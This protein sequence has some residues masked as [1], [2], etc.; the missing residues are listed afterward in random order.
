MRGVRSLYLILVLV[1]VL[2]ISSCD[3][4]NVIQESPYEFNCNIDSVYVSGLG[5]GATC[6]EDGVH[7]VCSE[8]DKVYYEIEYSGEGCDSVDALVIDIWDYWSLTD[9]ALSNLDYS[10]NSPDVS[11]IAISFE[12]IDGT[13]GTL[14]GAVAPVFYDGYM[15]PIECSEKIM[16]YQEGKVGVTAIKWD[17]NYPGDYDKAEKDYVYRTCDGCYINGEGPFSVDYGF[18]FAHSDTGCVGEEF[19][20]PSLPYSHP[21]PYICVRDN[22]GYEEGDPCDGVF[23]DED[24]TIHDYDRCCPSIEYCT[25]GGLC[26]PSTGNYDVPDDSEFSINIAEGLIWDHKN[27]GFCKGP[28]LISGS[29]G[30]GRW[31]DCDTDLGE[32]IN[33]HGQDDVP[34]YQCDNVLST[35]G[36]DRNACYV[37]NEIES[38]PSGEPLVGEYT[39]ISSIECCGDDSDE[40]LTTDGTI[41][42]CC[43]SADDYVNA[44]GLCS[45]YSEAGSFCDDGTC[46]SDEDCETC[47]EDCGIC[48]P[49]CDDGTCNSDEDCESCP[50]DC[51]VCTTENGDGDEG[52]GGGGSGSDCGD[53]YAEGSEECDMDDL[54]GQTCVGLGYDLGVLVCTEDCEFDE[55]GCLYEEVTP[56][57][58]EGNDN[59]FEEII[60]TYPKSKIWVLWVFIILAVA[61]AV[62][63]VVVARK[64]NER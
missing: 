44:V 58:T 11:G 57:D 39:Q 31:V 23:H 15:V 48:P 1:S 61:V 9:C 51:G 14:T 10:P 17:D 64:K 38:A 34:S 22:H 20:V 33:L 32:I 19:Y 56:V 54:D 27:I 55:S 26:Y 59:F 28:I 5:P 24:G 52:S 35:I 41:T 53:G 46:N 6:Q 60:T 50:E 3:V 4:E 43:D 25:Y 16:G 42:I 13:E 21:Y 12:N 37:V 7:G 36:D 8:G 30:G 45:E 47:P 2:F 18:K 29:I 62:I 63:S 40:Y 49:Y